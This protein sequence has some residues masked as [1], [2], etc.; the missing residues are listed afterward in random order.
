MT[1]KI[2]LQNKFQRELWKILKLKRTEIGNWNL[3]EMN[4]STILQLIYFFN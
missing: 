1:D 4:K 2:T 3:V